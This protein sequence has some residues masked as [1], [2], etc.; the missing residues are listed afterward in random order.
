M[1]GLVLAIISLALFGETALLNKIL[2][3]GLLYLFE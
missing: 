2:L 1:H 3:V